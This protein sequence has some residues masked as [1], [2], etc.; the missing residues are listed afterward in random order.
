MICGHF[1]VEK[2][3]PKIKDIFMDIIKRICL[4]MKEALILIDGSGTEN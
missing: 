1:V 4:L 3:Y 2:I